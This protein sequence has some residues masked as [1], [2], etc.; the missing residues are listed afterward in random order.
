MPAREDNL[1][2]P[3]QLVFDLDPGEGTT[4]K[5]V[6]QGARDIRARL[7]SAGLTTF[8]RTSG[9]KGLHVVVPLLRR[10]SW[11]EVKAFTHAIAERL[12]REAPDQFTA[13]LSKAQGQ[14]PDRLSAQSA[15]GD[16]DRV[17]FRARSTRCAAD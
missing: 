10:S 8:L 11:P 4:W 5:D 2:R 7:E 9:G 6:V 1:E 16:R 13:Q 12:V 17:V 15:R 14:D 3:D